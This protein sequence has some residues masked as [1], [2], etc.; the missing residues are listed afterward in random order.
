MDERL[1]FAV[2]G[3]P[4]KSMTDL[5]REFGSSRK[6]SYKIFDWRQECGVKGLADNSRR[7]SP[8]LLY[9]NLFDKFWQLTRR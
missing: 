6:T 5:R 8:A 2:C 7:R 9:L 1:Q 4:G 3:S